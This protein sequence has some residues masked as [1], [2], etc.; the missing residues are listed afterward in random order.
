MAGTSLK[1]GLNAEAPAWLQASVIGV[2]PS[3]CAAAAALVALL[4]LSTWIDS[5]LITWL[6]LGL[7]L[8]LYGMYV[9]WATPRLRVLRIYGDVLAAVLD[10]PIHK[11][12]NKVWGTHGPAWR[13]VGVSALVPLLGLI[14]PLMLLTLASMHPE[15]TSGRGVALGG[16][17]YRLDPISLLLVASSI[18]LIGAIGWFAY[19]A[20]KPDATTHLLSRAVREKGSVSSLVQQAV[21]LTRGEF[22]PSAASWIV[23]GAWYAWIG[24]YTFVR[25]ARL[26]QLDW[27]ARSAI[28]IVLSTVVVIYAIRR[29][30]SHGAPESVWIGVALAQLFGVILGGL[31]YAGAWNAFGT[32]LTEAASGGWPAPRAFAER[33]VLGL[34]TDV[35]MVLAAWWAAATGAHS[36]SEEAGVRGS[37]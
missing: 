34:I 5:R 29:A 22:P 6:P 32:L 13:M 31:V 10:V 21:D 17:G 33:M 9:V 3:A 19:R 20:S 2:F 35:P 14:V 15:V 7:G 12:R 30:R 8:V 11:A 27:P 16:G 24:D 4:P 36:R 28:W 23:L 25:A 26:L 1:E 18:P 37:R